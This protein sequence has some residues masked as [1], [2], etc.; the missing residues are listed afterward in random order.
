MESKILA[1]E[2]S[3]DKHIKIGSKIYEEL[4]YKKILWTCGF[5]KTSISSALFVIGFTLI[6][7]GL[8]NHPLFSSWNESA[9]VFGTIA[10]LSAFTV[11]YII[12]KKRETLKK[13]ELGR[14]Y[15]TIIKKIKQTN[16]KSNQ[17]IEILI[18]D[19]AEKLIQEAIYKH[20]MELNTPQN[21]DSNWQE[22][23]Y[24]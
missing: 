9:I 8:T 23:I 22:D 6:F 19:I 15:E 11:I 1:D 17:E 21:E 7:N 20:L 3:K 14:E 5:I 13:E 24:D 4:N 10:I 18:E 12:D 16:T 2:W